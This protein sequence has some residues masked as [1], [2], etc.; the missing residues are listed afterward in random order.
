MSKKIIKRKAIFESKNKE[1]NITMVREKM[2]RKIFFLVATKMEECETK[3]KPFFFKLQRKYAKI[4][5]A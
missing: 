2:K 3:K 1:K 4:E 5:D